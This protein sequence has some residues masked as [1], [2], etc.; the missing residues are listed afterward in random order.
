MKNL[1]WFDEARTEGVSARHTSSGTM[2]NYITIFKRW[3][4]LPIKY[5]NIYWRDT[6]DVGNTV[7]RD[8]HREIDKY[9]F[10]EQIVEKYLE[11][12]I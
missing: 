12:R 1:H 8:L 5:D 7:H 11:K 2:W 4:S 9:V 10:H 6:T 3:S